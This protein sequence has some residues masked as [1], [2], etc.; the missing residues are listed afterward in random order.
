MEREFLKFKAVIET[1]GNVD[2]VD[3]VLDD[4]QACYGKKQVKY[5]NKFYERFLNDMKYLIADID[6][7]Y[8]NVKG[9]ECLESHT[10]LG[11]KVDVCRY[12][13][14]KYNNLRCIFVILKKDDSIVILGVFLENGGKKK[15]KRI[16]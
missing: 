1:L 4:M 5:H 13:F 10:I 12:E 14:R 3:D 15:R 8:N 2:V 16:I 11:Y 9:F 7:A 6:V